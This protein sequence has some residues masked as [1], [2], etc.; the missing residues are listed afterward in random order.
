MFFAATGH[1]EQNIYMVPEA[2]L[3]VVFTG[4]IPDEIL[5]PTEGPMYRYILAACTD[6]PYEALH[7]TYADNGLIMEYPTGF[8]LAEIPLPET[9][10]LDSGSGLLQLRFDSYPFELIQV[11]WREAEP[12]LEPDTYRE[13]LF[14]SLSLQTGIELKS[15]D[16]WE[17]KKDQHAIFNQYFDYAEQGIQLRGVTGVWY[18]DETGRVIAFNYVTNPEVSDQALESKYQEHLDSLSCHDGG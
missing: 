8:N 10:T 9:G 14:G 15:G 11:M 6:M 4:F 3:I 2:E 7:Q 16:T 18:C 13:K 1:Y 17:S 12:G 5:H